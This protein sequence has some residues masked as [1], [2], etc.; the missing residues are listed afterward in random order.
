MLD[1]VKKRPSDDV[2]KKEAVEYM[3]KVTKSMEYTQERVMGLRDQMS[4]LLVKLG[5][6]NAA[7]EA[8]LER[9]VA[10]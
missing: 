8:I 3:T 2:S 10:R 6:R 1:M 4:S 7:F 5:P 9:I